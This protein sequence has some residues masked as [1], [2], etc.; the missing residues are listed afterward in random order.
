[1]FDTKQRRTLVQVLAAG[2]ACTVGLLLTA[3]SPAEVTLHGAEPV[4]RFTAT[5]VNMTGAGPP[6]VQTVEIAI[7]RWS[8]IDIRFDGDGKGV[9]KLGFATKITVNRKTG[10]IELEDFGIEAVRLTDVRSDKTPRS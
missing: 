2:L 1:M 6:G 9:G 5:A 7:D 8:L 4:E 10:T 3:S